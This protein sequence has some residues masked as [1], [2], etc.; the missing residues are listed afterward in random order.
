MRTA[1]LLAFTVLLSLTGFSQ[2]NEPKREYRK[3]SILGG[4]Q[5]QNFAL[6]FHDMESNFK[7]L[8]L[9][10]GSEISYNQKGTL[11]QQATL[12]GYLNREIGNG[13][14]V[15]TQFVYRQRILKNLHSELKAGLNYLRVF[16]P[17]QAYEYDNGTWKEVIGG[18]SQLGFPLDIGFTYSF[19]TSFAEL[20]PYISYQILPEFFYN[21]T[22]PLNIYTSYMIGL[23]V[24]LLKK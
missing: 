21:K 2:E 5:C 24:K 12:G 9:F 15:S 23:R 10:V 17:T 4:I 13:F 3:L 19:N 1:M 8:G 18:K 14:Y 7:H 22:L 20:S 16:H 6:P 11:V